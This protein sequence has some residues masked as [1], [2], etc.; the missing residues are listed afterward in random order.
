M[1]AFDVQGTF[2]TLITNNR[3]TTRHIIRLGYYC[4]EFN[5]R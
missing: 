2:A 4:A 3:V 1:G 5:R